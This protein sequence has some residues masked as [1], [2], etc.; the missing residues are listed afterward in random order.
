MILLVPTD[1]R[2]T[3]L[4]PMHPPPQG[5]NRNCGSKN[6]WANIA[7]IPLPKLLHQ[8]E[9]IRCVFLYKKRNSSNASLPMQRVIPAYTTK[10][11]YTLKLSFKTKS[12]LK[13]QNAWQMKDAKL[14]YDEVSALKPWV[15]QDY[16]AEV[17]IETLPRPLYY[18]NLVSCDFY[19]FL[20]FKNP[21][22]A[23]HF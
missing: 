20:S 16:L 13:D 2:Y 6:Q 14:C 5:K 1:C 10:N 11:I 21:L 23:R 22:T 9:F 4:K 3:A 8:G 7:Q 12:Y 15:V 18:P 17:N 19:L